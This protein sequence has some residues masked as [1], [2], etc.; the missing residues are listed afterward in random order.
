M[1]SRFEHATQ[2]AYD[3]MEK[4]REKS[5]EE[6]ANAKIMILFDTKIRLKGSKVVLGRMMKAND[7]IR[8]LTENFSPEGCDYVLFI[9]KIAWLNMKEKEKIRL[10][11][12]ELRHCKYNPFAKNP[13]QIEPHDIED[14]EVE[15]ELN[16]DDIGWAKRVA[17][18]VFYIYGQEKEKAEKPAKEQRKRKAAGENE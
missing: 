4:I 6:L 18:L 16:K 14:F 17:E 10:V 2:D 7:L 12:H 11:R 13:W 15:V 1:D 3:M 5:F 9:D 8:R